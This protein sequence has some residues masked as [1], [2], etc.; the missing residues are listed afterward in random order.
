M[1]QKHW[2]LIKNSDSKKYY[3]RMNVT[4]KQVDLRSDKDEV[5][6]CQNLDL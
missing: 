2:D 4:L 3:Q 5:I 1:T 6:G